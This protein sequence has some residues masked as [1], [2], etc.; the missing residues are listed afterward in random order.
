MVNEDQSTI[1]LH[2]LL[3]VANPDP[4][5]PVTVA[6]S[7]MTGA[8]MNS[9]AKCSWSDFLTAT[10]PD[11]YGEV[12]TTVIFDSSNV[13]GDTLPV[14]ISIVTDSLLEGDEEFTVT[15]TTSTTTVTTTVTIIDGLWP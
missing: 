7:D 11:D 14:T 5:I 6:T 4:D 15:T 1:V 12:N 2:V 10:T 3:L 9:L 8:E 13:V